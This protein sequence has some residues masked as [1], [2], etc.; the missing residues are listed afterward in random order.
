MVSAPDPDATD[1]GLA[2]VVLG[3]Q[4]H[5]TAT[6]AGRRAHGHD[7]LQ[8]LRPRTTRT[9]PG[10]LPSPTPLTS[11]TEMAATTSG[12]L[13]ADRAWHLP[14]DR[15]LL[16][17]HQQHRDHEPLQLRRRVGEGRQGDS[18]ARPRMPRPT[19][20]SAARSQRYG[21]DL[22][23][24]ETQAATIT[25]TA[26]GPDDANLRGHGRLHRHQPVT[27][28]TP[29][30]AP[31]TT[32][33][34]PSG[35]TAGSRLTPATPTTAPS[36]A[37]A[38]TPARSVA[39]PSRSR[40][41]PPTPRPTSRSAASSATRRRSPRQQPH[42]H[43]HLQRLR[44]GRRRLLGR[45]GLHRHRQNGQRRQRRLHLA[46]F[47]PTAVGTYRWRASYSGDGQNQ[48]GLGPCNDAGETAVVAKAKPTLAT[49]A[50]ANVTVGGQISDTATLAAGH[51][52]RRDDHLPR[53]RP[54]RR[55]TA[56]A[57]RPSPT[58]ST[59]PR[60]RRLR[61]PPTSR[62]PPPA[63]TAGSPPIAV[64]PNNQQAAGNCNDTGE[65]VAVAKASPTLT[66][67]GFRRRRGRR[68]G[69]RHR[70]ARLRSGPHGSR[71]PSTSTARTTRSARA[72]RS[73]T[74]RTSAAGNGSYASADF[75]PTEPGTY[76]WTAT[77]SGDANNNA[78]HQAPATPRAS[79]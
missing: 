2:D 38:T 44:P 5:D 24:A 30:T 13:H 69:S 28:A 67:T 48:R 32:R 55:P 33:R 50:S 9:A 64:M 15:R 4:V 8:C 62:R 56:P 53:L 25:F 75:T 29:A 43:H 21:D 68:P 40:R 76:R 78:G 26:Y 6:I 66:T 73:P 1:P 41:W 74:P 51:Q 52:P 45:R 22:G 18:D 61:P 54:E 63:P 36:P 71:S 10:P 37:P 16:G 57:R 39:S 11:T 31:A 59:S 14:L 23:R 46:D 60:Q 65:S 12:Q 20:R 72:R 49:S 77:Y 58:P 27:Q 35:S 7:Y 3:G 47:T 17:R 42:G 70:D 34:P 79:P 19:S